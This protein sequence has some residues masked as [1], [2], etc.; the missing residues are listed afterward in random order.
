MWGGAAAIGAGLLVVVPLTVSAQDGDDWVEA[1]L[2]G[3]V[4]DGTLTQDQA[5]AVESAL[6][7]A[8]PDG[9]DGPRNGHVRGGP[10]GGPFREPIELD[11]AAGAL[12][13]ERDE[14]LDELRHG[15]TIAELATRQRVDVRTVI[16]AMVAAVKTRLDDAVADGRLDA[17][18]EADRLADVTERITTFVDEGLPDRWVHH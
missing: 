17:T 16:D 14:L 1:T 6:D 10:F 4:T 8:R 7:T 5:D 2:D 9:V 15:T 12:G 3:L 11:S 18:D 13:I